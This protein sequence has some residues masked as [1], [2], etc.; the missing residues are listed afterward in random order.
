MIIFENAG[1]LDPRLITIMGVNVKETDSAIGYFGT[2]LKYAIAVLLR[3]GHKITIK[4]GSQQFSF[5]TSRDSIRGKEFEFVNMNDGVRQT[6]LGF[7]TELGKN[8]DVWQAYRELW[9]NTR[10]ESGHVYDG[11]EYKLATRFSDEIVARGEAHEGPA[12]TIQVSGPDIDR[13]HLDR[14]S[15]LLEGHPV[16]IAN[17]GSTVAEL[18]PVQ[19]TGVFFRGIKIY[20]L[21]KPTAYTY[22]FLSEVQLT[23]DRTAKYPWMFDGWIKSLICNSQNS[24]YIMESTLR[25]EETFEGNL[26]FNLLD[27]K[28]GQSFMDV[29]EAQE[30][31]I[32]LNPQ[33]RSLYFTTM[34]K[35]AGPVLKD[36]SPVQKKMIEKASAFLLSMGY[37][38]AKYPLKIVDS[39]GAGVMGIAK[40]REIWLSEIPFSKGTK[41]V[42]ATL[43]EEFLHLEYG[44]VD[45]SRTMQDWLLMKVI[46]LGEELGGAPL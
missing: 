36:L 32:K 38:I 13:V 37:N 10:D 9:S 20:D 15:F 7:T 39:L 25:G 18:F 17:Y 12:T 3:T 22:N 23:E 33:A 43:L 16:D 27:G 46:S 26:A 11:E 21:P 4:T 35:R 34:T 44:F 41:E 28:P 19:G 5:H 31:N 1:I 30:K 14:G 2:G 6:T 24:T 42:T 40:N 45:N 8:W 29:M